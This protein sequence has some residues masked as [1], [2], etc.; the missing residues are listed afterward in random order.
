MRLF[1]PTLT[2]TCLAAV[3]LLPPLSL[4]GGEPATPKPPELPKPAA[5]KADEPLA[6]TFSLAKSTEF[7]D[8]A[9][10][11]W[12]RSHIHILSLRIDI[13]LPP[14]LRARLV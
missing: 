12:F 11:Q 4:R 7:L 1:C 10:V 13:A 14:T 8:Q 5:T 6:K 2:D 9:A 3:L